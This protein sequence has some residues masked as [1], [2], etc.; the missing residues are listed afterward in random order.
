MFA[1]I[2]VS[3]I[4]MIIIGPRQS[5]MIADIKGRTEG[6][7]SVRRCL[8]P[9]KIALIASAPNGNLDRLYGFR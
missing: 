4:D 5:L 6:S 2:I 1:T 9:F 8:I 7:V 3:D